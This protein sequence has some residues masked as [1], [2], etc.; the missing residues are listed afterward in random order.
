MRLVVG[1][2]RDLALQFFRRTFGTLVPS[3]E[4]ARCITPEEQEYMAHKVTDSV[5]HG[6]GPHVG[7]PWVSGELEAL[8]FASM[9]GVDR[10]LFDRVELAAN[11]ILIFEGFVAH[12]GLWDLTGVQ[13]DPKD[14][15]WNEKVARTLFRNASRWAYLNAGERAVLRAMSE[16][17]HEWIGLLALVLGNDY[18]ELLGEEPSSILSTN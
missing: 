8:A 11:Q 17:V 14:S 12:G 2:D 7:C 10:A 9:S 18:L 5:V 16:H 13:H 6:S 1:Y 15:G 4:P 3:A